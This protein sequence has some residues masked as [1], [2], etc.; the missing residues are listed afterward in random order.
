MSLIYLQYVYMDTLWEE[1]GAIF[2]FSF[3]TEANSLRK[4]FLLQGNSFSFKRR[5]LFGR[6]VVAQEANSRQKVVFLR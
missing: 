6:F 1:K 4:E 2:I 5:T 3:S